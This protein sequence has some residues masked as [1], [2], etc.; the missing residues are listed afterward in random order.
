MRIPVIVGRWTFA[1]TQATV[2]RGGAR[3]IADTRVEPA[4]EPDPCRR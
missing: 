3:G 4:E 2:F 1:T